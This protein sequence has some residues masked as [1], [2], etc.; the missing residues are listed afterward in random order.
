METLS[1]LKTQHSLL[2]SKPLTATQI[3]AQK[4]TTKPIAFKPAIGFPSPNT[5]AEEAVCYS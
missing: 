4:C 1:I 2:V 5:A 3:Y